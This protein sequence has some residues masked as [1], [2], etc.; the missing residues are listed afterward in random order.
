[1]SGEG[2]SHEIP[3]E[4]TD[5]D[6]WL[7]LFS[8]KSFAVLGVG[9]VL[10]LGLYKLFGLFSLS[11]AG[12]IPGLLLTV[13]AVGITMIPKMGDDYMT[14]AGQKLDRLLLL[15]IVRKR[16][17]CIYVKGYGKEEK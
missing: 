1:M 17:R 14:G 6:R 2:M 5:E 16:N 12:G 4:F 10:T 15:R 8:T 9:G 13:F 11:L 3:S 7:N